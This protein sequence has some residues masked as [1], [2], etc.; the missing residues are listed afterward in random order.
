MALAGCGA[1]SWKGGES[2][3][4]SAEQGALK[5]CRDGN[6]QACILYAVD[7]EVVFD[8]TVWSGLWGP[9]L[10][11]AQASRAPTGLNRRERF[12]NLSFR[13]AAGKPMTL[14]SLRGKVV[15]LHFWGSWC[16]PCRQEMPELQQLQRALGESPDIRMVLLQVREDFA[17]ARK[18]ARQQHLELPLYDSGA[19]K[20]ANGMLRMAEGKPVHDRYIAEV[21]PTTYILDK[22]GIVVFSNAGP[23]SH[24]LQY[25][26][27]LRDAAARSGK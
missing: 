21:F 5:A 20:H 11:R 24:W 2:T 4:E 16:S 13:N 6:G 12:Y 23:V 9:Y 25:L 10:N 3:A 17:T 19:G 26:P 22:H 8:D 18:W 27:L 14:S 15:L 7:D 1:W